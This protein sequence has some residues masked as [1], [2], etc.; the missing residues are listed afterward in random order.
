MRVTG[1]DIRATVIGEGANLGMTQR[2]RIEAALSGVRLNT[3]AI[4]NSAGV[5][6][7]DYEV[8]IKIALA[9][10]LADGRLKPDA[11]NA[12]LARMTDE[13]AQL[14]LANNHRQTLALSLAQRRG[15]EDLGFEQR[16]MQDLEGQGLLDREVEFLPDDA[17]LTRR[18]RDGQPLTRP[19]LSVLLAYAKNTLF[20]ALLETGVP[21]DP[22]LG[23]ELARY[24][25]AP[26]RETYR[27][28][29]DAHR[30]R[31][32]IIATRL[33][34]AMIDLGGP[35]L[36]VRV[37]GA[38]VETAAAAFAAVHDSFR[39]HEL[40]S[41]LN[42]LDAKIPGGLQLELYAAVQDVL[43]SRMNWFLRNVP[44]SEGL[45][46]VVRR[47]RDGV[48]AVRD[49]LSHALAPEAEQARRARAIELVASGVPEDLALDLASLPALRGAPNAVLIAEQSGLPIADATATL[50]A[51]SDRFALDRLRASALALP[52]A[53]H[54]ER[55]A[56]D[57]AVAEIGI[58]ER[59][60]AVSATR[61]GIGPDAIAAWAAANPSCSR[62]AKALDDI[63]RSGL[64]LAK[65]TVA[66]DMLGEL[67]KV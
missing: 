65:L 46:S 27:E 55:M 9:S 50:F 47:F 12:F 19:E 14:V 48:D 5:N 57:N 38:N 44:V 52:V 36:L 63:A 66:A 4:D 23:R 10:A 16:L 6:T 33:A 39:L 61:H 8:N 40:T 60:I 21:D 24:F 41:G 62:A 28:D 22:Y 54:Y 20:A 67:L 29:I 1:K 7:S 18:A 42:A 43:L 30:L 2:G 31:R 17:D 25:P 56:I 45:E 53:D 13:V 49:A 32:E 51:I 37:H 3:D 64:T 26:L 59:G 11:R 58:A 34:N 15:T 35:S